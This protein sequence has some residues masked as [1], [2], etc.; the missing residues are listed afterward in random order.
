VHPKAKEEAD[1]LADARRAEVTS[2][3]RLALDPVRV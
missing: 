2:L 1:P 3:W